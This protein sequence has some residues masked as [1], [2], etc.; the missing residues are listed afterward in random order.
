MKLNPYMKNKYRAMQPISLMTKIFEKC[1]INI[2]KD[3]WKATKGF[4]IVLK[5]KIMKNI[6]KRFSWNLLKTKRVSKMQAVYGGFHFQ[7]FAILHFILCLSSM[8]L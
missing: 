4:I 3:L 5:W 6:E 1:F 7:M 8:Q 2:L